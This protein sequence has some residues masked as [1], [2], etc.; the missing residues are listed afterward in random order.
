M[1]PF[2]TESKTDAAQCRSEE[3]ANCSVGEKWRNSA[4]FLR[5]GG[6]FFLL[7]GGISTLFLCRYVPVF[8]LNQQSF[9]FTARTE[10]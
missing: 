4:Y 3:G 8:L 2:H 1:I 6:A 5:A 10:Q 7:L 9:R